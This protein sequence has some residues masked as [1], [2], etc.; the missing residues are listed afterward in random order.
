M[1]KPTANRD[2]IQDLLDE[3]WACVSELDPA[4]ARRAARQILALLENLIRSLPSADIQASLATWLDA[5]T[6][7]AGAAC[8]QP[9][10]GV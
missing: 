6:K 9:M 10:M 1:P 4:G 2:P 3:G 7:Q 8:P 5:K